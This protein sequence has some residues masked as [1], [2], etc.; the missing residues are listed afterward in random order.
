MKNSG[1]ICAY[2][3]TLYALVFVAERRK[4]IEF[5]SRKLDSKPKFMKWIIFSQK[6]L[7][8]PQKLTQDWYP[9]LISYPILELFNLCASDNQQVL[10]RIKHGLH[11]WKIKTNKLYLGIIHLMLI[12]SASYQYGQWGTRKF[13]AFLT[14]HPPQ[15]LVFKF[16]FPFL[17]LWNQI[18]SQTW[19]VGSLLQRVQCCHCKSMHFNLWMKQ[20]ECVGFQTWFSRVVNHQITK[21][22]C[23]HKNC[24]SM[25][26]VTR[27]ES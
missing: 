17:L 25:T 6:F 20:F 26:W 7:S 23:R 24:P 4:E 3:M 5:S 11:D 2:A 27:L 13:Y 16:L 9:T 10:A 15:S 22:H 1:W 18:D 8:T 21:F 19:C 14:L 12:F